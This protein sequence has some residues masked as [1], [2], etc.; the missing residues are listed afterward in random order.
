[1]LYLGSF[2][3]IGRVGRIKNTRELIIKYTDYIVAYEIKNNKIIILTVRHGKRLW[4][5]FF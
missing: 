5:K 3:E 4:P 2:P 1:M